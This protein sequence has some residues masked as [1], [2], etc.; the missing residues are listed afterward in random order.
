MLKNNKKF[1][2][3]I[4][5][6][7]ITLLSFSNVSFAQQN[8]FS[9]DIKTTDDYGYDVNKMILGNNENII[10]PASATGII[11]PVS[12]YKKDKTVSRST[13]KNFAQATVAI[14]FI[15]KLHGVPTS[16][17]TKKYG[18]LMLALQALGYSNVYYTRTLYTSPDGFMYYYKY[19]YYSDSGHKDYIKTSYSSVYGKWAR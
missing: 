3:L 17:V 7:C 6:F 16:T 4:L 10:S 15:A 9:A 13:Y 5:V 14:A 11:G 2:S 18:T 1:F 19:K 8:S 12:G